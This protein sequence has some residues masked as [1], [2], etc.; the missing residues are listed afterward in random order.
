MLK[1][2]AA[3]ARV[4]WTGQWLTAS[5]QSSSP[6]ATIAI[7]LLILLRLLLFN[8]CLNDLLNIADLDEDIFGFEIR[9]DDTTFTMK[10]IQTQQ[11]L[12]GDLLHQNH[13]D[14]PMIPALDQTQ[15]ILPQD[16]K[17]HAD[18]DPVGTFVF[19]GI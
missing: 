7:V 15:Q 19:E 11:N 6:P 9:M 2:E 17:D 18:V 3:K 4:E 1:V 12:L 8:V 14:S 5:N 10:V 16:L 13:G